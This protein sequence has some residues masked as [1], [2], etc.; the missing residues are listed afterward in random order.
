MGKR[1]KQWAAKARLT[2]R[3]ELGMK[4]ARCGSK[5]Y[6]KLQFDVMQPCDNGRHHKLDWSARMSFY[7]AQHRLNNIQL[8]CPDCH[9]GKT[10]QENYANHPA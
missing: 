6:S 7:R 2:L 8:L 5:Y 4:C 9:A 1:Q 10:Y 3:R